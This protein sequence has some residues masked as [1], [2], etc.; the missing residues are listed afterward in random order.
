MYKNRYLKEKG[1]L[2]IVFPNKIYWTLTSWKQFAST[3]LVD[4][5][6]FKGPVIIYGWGDRSQ[7]W[8][9]IE[10]ILQPREWASKLFLCIKI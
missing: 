7:K 6:L 9:G 4:N 3:F 1:N 2:D 5:I 10:I 8:V